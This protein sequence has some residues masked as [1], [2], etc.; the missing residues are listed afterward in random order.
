MT[1]AERYGMSHDSCG[2]EWHQVVIRKPELTNGNVLSVLLDKLLARSVPTANWAVVSGIE[3]AGDPTRGITRMG[4]AKIGKQDL[5]TRLRYS[6]QLDWAN[7][8]FF[9]DIGDHA[10]NEICSEL[11]IPD[12]IAV[13]LLSVRVVDD[14]EVHVF[15]TDA[16]LRAHLT[17]SYA[18]S[19]SRTG[20]LSTL[21]YPA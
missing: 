4:C 13:S 3:G 15:T 12:A 17:E 6:E 21:D 1:D 7:F 10:V 11:S 20:P 2:L 9:A 5:L 8:F 18:E 16:R 14:S 19:Y